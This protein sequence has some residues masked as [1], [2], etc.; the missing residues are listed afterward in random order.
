MKK[1]N[2]GAQAPAFNSI[3]PATIDPRVFRKLE[4]LCS[5]ALQYGQNHSQVRDAIAALNLEM[6][7][8]S[9]ERLGHDGVD[10]SALSQL[11]KRTDPNKPL[12]HKAPAPLRDPVDIL[13]REGKLDAVQENAASCIREVWNAFGRCLT[14]SGRGYDRGGGGIRRASALQPLDVMGEDTWALYQGTFVPWYNRAK[15]AKVGCQ[16]TGNVTR[17]QI[18]F[19]VVIDEFF[20]EQVDKFLRLEGGTALRVVQGQLASFFTGEPQHMVQIGT[21][22]GGLAV[23]MVMPGEAAKAA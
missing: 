21:T 5:I 11:L 23:G 13:A 7:K 4:A 20:P 15:E 1:G 22:E 3:I 8:V 18:V 16:S 19:R 6:R 17:L 2:R 12:V 14:V 9:G 10:V